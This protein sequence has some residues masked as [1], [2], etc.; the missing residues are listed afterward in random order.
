[1]NAIPW[2]RDVRQRLARDCAILTRENSLL[3]TLLDAGSPGATASTL[4]RFQKTDD[5]FGNVDTVGVLFRMEQDP[6]LEAFSAWI[7]RAL[8]DSRAGEV[9]INGRSVSITD[10]DLGAKVRLFLCE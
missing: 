7:T 4:K 9:V 5:V 8:R 1:M 2:M 3:D 6:D 10:P